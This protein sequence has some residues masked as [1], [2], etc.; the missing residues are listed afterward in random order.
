MNGTFYGTSQGGGNP[1]CGGGCGT[2]FK[3]TKKGVETVLYSFAGGTDGSGPGGGLIDVDGTLYG[4]TGYGGDTA[5]DGGLGCGTF[6]SISTSGIENVLYR[7]QGGSDGQSPSG[8]LLDF[9]GTLYGTTQLGGGQSCSQIGCGTVFSVTT[10]GVESVIHSFAGG[11]DGAIPLAGLTKVGAAFYGTTA[12]GGSGCNGPSCGTVFKIT[13]SGIET[14]VYDFKA[15]AD[16]ESPEA[17]LTNENGTLYGTTYHGGTSN[18]GTIFSATT[19]GTESVLYSFA[20]GSDGQNP[21]A[22]LNAVNGL[23]YGTTFFGG[24]GT[25]CGSSGCGTVFSVTTAGAETVLYSFAGGS[26]G[27][28]PAAGLISLKQMLYGTTYQGGGQACSEHQG[29]GTVFTLSP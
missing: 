26:D 12:G 14:I 16:G 17:S 8:N 9:K 6:F 4:T 29:C 10:S 2:V 1:A 21:Q 20:G 11:A 3:I 23:L 7:F 28:Y 27:E 5:C 15:G 25:A 22:P 24:T 18:L 13:P 19:T